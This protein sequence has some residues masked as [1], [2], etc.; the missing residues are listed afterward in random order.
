M[1]TAELNPL[2][3]AKP[4]GSADRVARA[5]GSSATDATLMRRMRGGD[6]RAFEAI[7]KRHH[8]PLLSYCRHMLASRDEAEDALQQTFIRAHKAL[9]GESPPRELRPWLYAI[10]RNC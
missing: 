4:T 2:A 3:P 5:G 10:A 7:F 9:S 6:E 1:P 8:A